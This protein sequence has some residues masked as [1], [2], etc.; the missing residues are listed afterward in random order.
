MN[1]D[2]IRHLVRE[3]LVDEL[4]RMG[5]DRRGADADTSPHPQ[6]RV[7]RIAMRTD[8]DLRR[9]ALR[10]F[11]LAADGRSVQE[12]KAGRWVFRLD[13][14]AGVAAGAGS[15]MEPGSGHALGSAAP[16]VLKFDRGLVT[17]RQVDGLSHGS[18][19]RI[20]RHVRFT[21]LARDEIRRKGIHVERKS[22]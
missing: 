16:E 12:I 4:E 22:T 18:Q 20:G 3:V 19:L 1:S 7:E 6:I 10:M 15:V 2:D 9:F 8:A 14:G 17:E 5:A 13:G 21:P 11:E